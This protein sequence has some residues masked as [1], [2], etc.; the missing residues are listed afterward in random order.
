MTSTNA[1]H[2]QPVD[3]KATDINICGKIIYVTKHGVCKE[4]G[5]P[6]IRRDFVYYTG[7]YGYPLLPLLFV[8][9][10]D[11]QVDLPWRMSPEKW[12]VLCSR[13]CAEGDE[14]AR[15]GPSPPDW[16]RRISTHG[17]QVVLAVMR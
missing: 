16:R 10:G 8:R 13:L 5:D 15:Q 1:I 7:A 11:K 17:I 9:G 14:G 12:Y 4:G 6:A 2:F 3:G